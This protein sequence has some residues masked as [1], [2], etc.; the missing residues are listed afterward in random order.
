MENSSGGLRQHDAP[1]DPA[2]RAPASHEAAVDLLE[3]EFKAVVVGAV[4]YDERRRAM[5]RDARNRK[6]PS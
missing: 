4:G 3:R 6:R 1:E 2:A 5:R